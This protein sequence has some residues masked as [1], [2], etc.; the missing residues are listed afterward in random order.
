M[1]FTILAVGITSQVPPPEVKTRYDD[2]EVVLEGL[3]PNAPSEDAVECKH[4]VA[5][6][7]GVEH[8]LGTST[9]VMRRG[10]KSMAFSTCFANKMPSFNMSLSMF[11]FFKGQKSVYENKF[12]NLSTNVEFDE[13]RLALLEDKK[14]LVSNPVFQEYFCLLYT[15]P[16]PRDLSTS[17]MPSSA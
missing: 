9:D 8:V 6:S 11:C 1:I 5:L 4:S 13:M 15:S 3:C 2:Y 14:A 7:Q 10:G 16:S 12:N 17:R